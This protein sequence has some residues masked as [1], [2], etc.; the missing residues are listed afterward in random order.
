MRRPAIETFTFSVD[1]ERDMSLISSQLLESIWK[2]N[3]CNSLKYNNLYH[4]ECCINIYSPREIAGEAINKSLF[5]HPY[6][7]P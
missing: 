7:S 3:F 5:I 2:M 6:E 1:L 4:A